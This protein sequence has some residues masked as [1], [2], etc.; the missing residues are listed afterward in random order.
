MK[1]KFKKGI[2]VF[3]A[4]MIIL[5]YGISEHPVHIMKATVDSFFQFA[6]G[7][8]SFLELRASIADIFDEK[9]LVY[10][11][12]LMDINSLYLRYSGATSV[13][14]DDTTV[15]RLNNGH[16]TSTSYFISDELVQESAMEIN[17]LYQ[18]SRNAGADFLYVACPE[19]GYSTNYPAGIDNYVPSNC[20]RFYKALE[21]MGVPALVLQ[22]KMNEEGIS[23]TEAFFA[24]DHHWKPEIGL[25]ATGK[26]LEEME[27]LYHI[28]YNAEY[29]DI[30]NYDTVNYEEWFLGSQ[31]K[32]T[33]V[34]FTELGAD[35]ITLITPKFET[36]FIEEQPYKD[37]QRSGN[38]TETVMYLDNI[39]EKNWYIKNPYAAYCGGDFRMQI[40][41]NQ[42]AKNSRKTLVIRDSFACV[43]APF[44]ALQN[45]ILYLV[46]IRDFSY[47]VG[48]KPNVYNLIDEIQPDCVL[49][50]Y[51]GVAT[52]GEGGRLN[53]E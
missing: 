35:D 19:K 23:E 7:K 32:K 31:G 11:D 53:F 13:Q 20:S 18:Y 33:G 17:K 15:V 41:R 36:S 50:V 2:V 38:F 30:A 47:F 24:T 39:Q 52:V 34:Y 48:E 40:F 1:I 37:W 43:V 4:V 8:S 22:D 10:H 12:A 25:W 9:G 42:M 49:V 6:T 44:L 29:T 5:G 14:K 45:D 51:T 3:V 27:W 16:L 21:S 46:D 26:I 28:P